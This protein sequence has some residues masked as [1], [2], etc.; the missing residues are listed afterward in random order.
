MDK[1]K[2]VG[3]VRELFR[4]SGYK[5]DTSVEINHREIDV[6]AEETQGLV[7][8]IVLVEC[9]DLS[10]PVGIRK[11]QEDIGKL[12]SATEVLRDNAVIMH[13]SRNGYTAKAYGY[14]SDRGIPV[15][16]VEDLKNQL[17]NF[18]AYIDAVDS[19]PL[20][21]VIRR[22]YQQSPIHYE[23]APM[24][25]MESLRFLDDWLGGETKWLTL[26]GDYGVGKSWT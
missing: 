21:A 4:V 15:F 14:A 9:A 25:P 7:R 23:N 8:K 20:Q 24:Q 16:G 26:L 12:H 11:I 17:I 1:T 5:V 2:L 3:E 22:E 18:D 6:R 10:Q 19:E 13:V